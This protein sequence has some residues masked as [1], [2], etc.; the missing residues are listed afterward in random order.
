MRN[1]LMAP[2]IALAA[3]TTF[4]SSTQAQQV[5]QRPGELEQRPPSLYQK[6]QGTGPGGPAPR[7]DLSGSWTGPLEPK[8]G[9]V[10]PMTALG[11]ARFKLNIPDP[12]SAH[13]N[14]PW[15]TCDPFGFPRSATNETRGIAFAQMPDRVVIMTQF[16]KVWRQVWMDGRELPKNVGAKGGPDSKWYGYSVGHWDGDYTL[17]VE[18]TGVDDST[19]VDRRGYPHSVEMRVEER[20]TRVDHN[21]L[22]LTVTV[23]DPKIY[24]KP[25]V[26]A[27]N[28]FKWIPNQEDEEQLCVPSEAISYLNTVAIPAGQDRANDKK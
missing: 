1:L 20:Y 13:S 14:D 18:T 25:F 7:R 6:I 23:D 26:I 3:L 19:W 16:Q 4:S 5:F 2:L 22:E 28:K 8:A 11:Q 15:A 17:V 10:P 27:T 24:T 21:D 9:D 12:F